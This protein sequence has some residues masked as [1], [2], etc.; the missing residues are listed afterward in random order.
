[1]LEFGKRAWRAVRRVR[2]ESKSGAVTWAFCLSSNRDGNESVATSLKVAP[3]IQE[4][5][6]SLALEICCKHRRCHLDVA[7]TT[8]KL[9]VVAVCRRR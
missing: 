7:G 8:L 3:F 1:M 9:V 6:C 4:I 2:E 5:Y